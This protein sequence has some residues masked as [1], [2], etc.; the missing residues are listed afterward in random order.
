VNPE[1]PAAR[2]LREARKGAAGSALE[3]LLCQQLVA[4]D[5]GGFVKQYKV[6]GPDRNWTFD[7]AY[8]GDALLVEVDGGTF[9]GGRHTR[10]LGYEGDREKDN[11][12]Q[13]WGWRV[14]RFTAQQVK[15]GQAA[16]TMQV[17]LAMVRG[18]KPWHYLVDGKERGTLCEAVL[19][20][21]VTWYNGTRKS[22]RKNTTKRG[23]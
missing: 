7:L 9:A 16:A 10:G 14:Y 17:A 11:T 23:T 3:A 20:G 6:P 1:P 12:V 13:L 15:T 4:L 8:V 19:Q 5:L 18:G 2:A 21:T 22:R